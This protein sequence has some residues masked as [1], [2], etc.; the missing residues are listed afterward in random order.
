[1]KAL[2]VYDSNFGNTKLVAEK[3]AANLGPGTEAVSVS[4]ATKTVLA[5][6]DLLVLGSPIYQWAPTVSTQK[7]L[8]TLPDWSLKGVKA[9]TFD[10][11][12]RLFHGDAKEKMAQALKDLG[13]EIVIPPEHFF[14]SGAQGPL[15]RGELEHAAEWG[16]KIAGL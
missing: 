1:M 4:V 6:V 7:F 15:S 8:D 14:V 3:I 12:V 16:K 2:V 5:G 10:T 13:A 9:T 11:R